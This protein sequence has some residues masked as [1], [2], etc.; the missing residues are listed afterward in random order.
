M[1]RG[2]SES[3]ILEDGLGLVPDVRSLWYREPYSP[4][5][6]LGVHKRAAHVLAAWE[7]EHAQT[8]ALGY[9]VETQV[10]DSDSPRTATI[11]DF[12]E[13]LERHIAAFKEGHNT[14]MAELVMIVRSTSEKSSNYDGI[15]RG[16]P[17]VAPA[18]GCEF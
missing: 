13:L 6:P 8:R 5:S 14:N 18:M 17:D 4:V 12:E 9:D 2:T 11:E 3:R 7:T 1:S 10:T 15:T 16:D